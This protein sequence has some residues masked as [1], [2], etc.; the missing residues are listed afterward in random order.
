M[1]TRKPLIFGLYEQANIGDG[2]GAASLWTHPE[3]RRLTSVKSYDYWL[4][5][6]KLADEIN[7]D[8]LFFGDVLGIYDTYGQ[9]PDTA[10]SWGVELPAH[11]PLMIIPALAAATRHLAFGATI[12]TS[13]DHPFAHARRLSTLDHMTGGRIGWNIV[14][15]YLPSAA[16]NFGRDRMV[17]HDERYAIAEEFLEVS[18]KLWEGSWADDAF[19]GDKTACRFADA[20][21]VR[22]ID[23]R[24]THF[25][26]AGPHVSFPSPQRTPLLIQAG[27]SPRGKIF[28]AR[29]AEVVFV[30][31][32]TAG[33]VRQGVE[34]IR[35]LARAEGRDGGDIK[36]L[37]GAQ[38]VV[39]AT[40]AEAEDKL[41]DYQRFYAPEAS[42]AAYSGYSGIDMARYQDDEA[43]DRSSNHTQSAASKAAV[44]AGDIR[45]RY[46]RVDGNSGLTFIGSPT[47]IANQIAAYVD[48][49]GIDGFLLHQFIAPASF[50]DFARYVVP[51][52][53]A[54]GLYRTE[55]QTGTLRAR[56]R[57]DG[58]DRL[59]D[60]HPAARFRWR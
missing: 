37:A 31:D 27:W 49:S 24:G 42:L 1:T 28:G 5:L 57:A 14:T 51:A 56:L 8:L 22:P 26:C 55:A 10:I 7:L 38:I 6:A 17:P 46:A 48:Q 2:S 9:S 25:A 54:R 19:L 29:H 18:Y 40:R 41:A 20:T 50:E 4:H 45:Q 39:G 43:I 12:S 47:E 60:N 15:S 35:T 33:A 23:H 34:D 11:D 3:D 36:A 44:L 59:P 21:R 52:L 16:R 53:Q 30:G 58:A 32:N 13:Y